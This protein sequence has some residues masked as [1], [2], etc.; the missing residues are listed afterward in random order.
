MTIIFLGVKT[1]VGMKEILYKE[2]SASLVG[3]NKIGEVAITV[4]GDGV[5]MSVLK[6]V[7]VRSVLLIIVPS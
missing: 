7:Y 3:L 1:L 6:V 2:F 5:G 4:V